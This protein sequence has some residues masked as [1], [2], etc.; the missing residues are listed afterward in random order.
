MDKRLQIVWRNAGFQ[1]E[2]APPGKEFG[3]DET[4]HSKITDVFVDEANEDCPCTIIV[5][6]GDGNKKGT[7]KK[8]EKGSASNRYFE[9]WF[10]LCFLKQLYIYFP[11]PFFRRWIRWIDDVSKTA[12]KSSQIGLCGRGLFVAQVL[13]P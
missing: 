5:A 10:S 7:E 12:Q 1:V 11:F 4:L 9:L 13:Q 2:T 6:T 8:R 3:I